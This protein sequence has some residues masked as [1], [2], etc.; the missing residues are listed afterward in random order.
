MY[1]IARPNSMQF[2]NIFQR[3][4]LLILAMENIDLITI[5]NNKGHSLE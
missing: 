5:D 3:W 1:K 4:V 2:L